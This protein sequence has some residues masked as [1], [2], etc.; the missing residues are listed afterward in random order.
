[1]RAQ[2]RVVGAVV[3]RELRVAARYPI[4]VFNLLVL[5]PL[6]QLVLPALL[7]GAA[8]TVAGRAPGLARTA[9]T[10][11]VAGW[12]TIGMAGSA[13]VVGVI[14]GIAHAIQTDRQLGTIE[15]SWAAPVSRQA[16]L[17][18]TVASST[19]MAA[20]GALIMIALGALVFGASYG[21]GIWLVL[22]LV[23]LSLP[24]MVGLALLVS[25]I[26][27]RWRHADEIVDGLGYV[28]AIL[29]GVVFPVSIL[30][31]GLEAVAYAL[32][33]TWVIDLSRV[34][35]LGGR[36][37]WSVPAEVAWLAGTSAVWLVTGRWLFQ[38]TERR[39]M[40]DGTLA[41]H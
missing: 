18:G 36:P 41:Q 26:V 39:L 2:V 27:L 31:E 21:P 17:L 20:M 24:G 32:P 12:L 9:G 23:S 19:V 22:P 15:H 7:L 8:F 33:S 34:A 10:Q 5:V 28:L 35:A 16:L 6:Y 30:P 29:S 38:R 25:V 14:W 1:M 3:S 4:S 37:L 13:L 40:V 11:D